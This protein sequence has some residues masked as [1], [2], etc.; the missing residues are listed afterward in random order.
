MKKGR[1]GNWVKKDQN[2]SLTVRERKD[3]CGAENI[4]KKRK[5]INEK[6]E[7]WIREICF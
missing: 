3:W 2:K 4:D 1:R 5:K 7:E 6:W